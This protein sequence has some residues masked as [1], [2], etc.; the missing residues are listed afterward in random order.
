MRYWIPCEKQYVARNF[1][2]YFPPEGTNYVGDNFHG[3]L[4][5]DTITIFVYAERMV[6]AFTSSLG[7]YFARVLLYVNIYATFHFLKKWSRNERGALNARSLF[8]SGAVT[9]MS[10]TIYVTECAKCNP[11][12]TWMATSVASSL[13]DYIFCN[14]YCRATYR[15]E[16]NWFAMPHK[17]KLGPLFRMVPAFNWL[18]Q[19]SIGFSCDTTRT[20]VLLLMSLHYVLCAYRVHLFYRLGKLKQLSMLC[21][22]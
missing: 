1:F 19:T 14:M 15:D 9:K 10:L 7:Y 22:I 16:P 4:A 2:D 11:C 5:H 13:D 21:F 18:C 12:S 6:N 8:H 20:F 3:K 17:M